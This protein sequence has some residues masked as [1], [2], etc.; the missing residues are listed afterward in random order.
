MT[1]SCFHEQYYA[2]AQAVSHQLLTLKTLVDA[3]GNPCALMVDKVSL[4][5]D[6]F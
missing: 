5:Q 3:Q 6:A 1:A 2:I 4:G